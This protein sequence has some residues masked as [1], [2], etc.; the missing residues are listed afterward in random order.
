M[1][2]P[3][4]KAAMKIGLSELQRIQNDLLPKAA[5]EDPAK[6]RALFLH[7]E[8]KRKASSWTNTLEGSRKVRGF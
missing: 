7:D 6:K 4:A 8:S 5:Q 1:P 3:A 2:G